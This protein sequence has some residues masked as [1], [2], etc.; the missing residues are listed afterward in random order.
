[1]ASN[2]VV[3]TAVTKLIAS[4]ARKLKKTST[5][6]AK[7]AVVT[8]LLRDVKHPPRSEKARF[9]LLIR[10]GKYL[11]TP[12]YRALIVGGTVGGVGASVTF[13]ATSIGYLVHS[14]FTE[15]KSSAVIAA[16]T[17]VMSLLSSYVAYKSVAAGTKQLRRNFAM[18]PRDSK[19]IHRRSR[20]RERVS[21]LL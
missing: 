13:G 19:S 10:I 14:M 5:P 18:T 16:A 21:I 9:D 11:K 1:M 12:A 6:A 4:E 20:R 2:Q 8:R 7:K 15:S 3:N 17:S